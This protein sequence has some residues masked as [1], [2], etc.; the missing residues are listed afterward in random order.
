MGKGNQPGE[1]PSFRQLCL[2]FSNS[3]CPVSQLSNNQQLSLGCSCGQTDRQCSA[4]CLHGP[5]AWL[6][7]P[8]WQA[9]V[10]GGG[11]TTG[12]GL[13]FF[14]CPGSVV[15]HG[16]QAASLSFTWLAQAGLS[17]DHHLAWL[18][19]GSCSKQAGAGVSALLSVLCGPLQLLLL[20]FVVVVAAWLGG[21]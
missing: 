12:Q 18:A 13:G 6:A 7:A 20:L 8:G 15:M 9:Q 10:G 11:L 17:T 4:A 2:P 14:C 1:G 19:Q 16:M 5:A 3:S 21:E